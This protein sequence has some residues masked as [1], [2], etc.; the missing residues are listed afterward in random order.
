MRLR[1]TGR[2]FGSGRWGRS[3][4]GSKGMGALGVGGLSSDRGKF[5][6]R[7]IARGGGGVEG[8]ENFHSQRMAE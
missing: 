2:G 3:E 6:R 4:E 7:W 8:G 5:M 1:P